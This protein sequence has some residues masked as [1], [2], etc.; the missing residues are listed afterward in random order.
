MMLPVVFVSTIARGAPDSTPLK[1]PAGFGRKHG[2]QAD[3][4]A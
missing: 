1:T 3:S 4:T 2:F